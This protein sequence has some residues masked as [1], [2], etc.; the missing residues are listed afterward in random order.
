MLSGW[1]AMLARLAHDFGAG[2]AAVDPLQPTR[3]N[4]SCA[5]CRLPT[6]CRRDE[7]LR[8]GAIGDD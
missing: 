8:A 3:R 1:H 4:G 6:L 5:Y 2:H 7:L